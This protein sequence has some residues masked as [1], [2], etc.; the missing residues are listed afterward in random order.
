MSIL[1]SFNIGVTGLHAA[2]QSM[3]VVG[4]NIANAGTFGF[5]GS[6]AEFQ[7]MLS[8]SLKG[9]DGG[10][11][12]GS[13]TKL[14]HITP[15]FTQGTVARTQNITD[16]AING[17]GFFKVAAPFGEGFTRDGSF[18]FDK[19]GNMVNG[20][21]YRVQGFLPDEKGSISNKSGDIKLGNTNI[22]AT[23][24]T[25]VKLSMNLDSRESVKVFDPKNPDK[26]SN[27]NS[28]ITVYD[29]VGTARL[30]TLYYNKTADGQW[31]YHA[32]AD[33]A[34][35]QN[36]KAGEMVEMANGKLIFDQKGVLQD[37]QPGL[38]A[39]NFNKG[40]IAGQKIDFNFG[41]TVKDG[42]NGAESTITQYG[43]KSSIARHSQDG[44]SAATLASM[45]FNDEGILTAVYDNGQQRNLGQVAIAKFENNEGLFKTGKNLYKET[46]KSGQAAMGKPGA[47]GRGEVLSKSIEQSNVD[48][49]TEFISLMGAQRNFQANT[50]T[51]TTSDQMLQ[52]VLN[53]KR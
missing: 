19:E 6:R 18:H 36:G 2:G 48:I 21:G 45:S 3:G 22:P 43:S 10:D 14:A 51:I 52:E 27:F 29:S 47:D 16:L 28:S 26:T 40:A 49:A 42:G 44:S 12:M 46:R 15:Q 30:V 11:Q 9:I 17:N 37:E 53:I 33:G 32:M 50:R 1:S 5:K 25:E 38:N 41:K 24:T 39:F 13:G 34:D 35:V 7:D 4:D 31:D 20:D 23:A 8:T